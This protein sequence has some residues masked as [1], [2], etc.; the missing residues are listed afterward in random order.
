MAPLVL[1][2]GVTEPAAAEDRAALEVAT[3]VAD[4]TDDTREVVFRKPVVVGTTV[5]VLELLVNRDEV[6]TTVALW[7]TEV[8]LWAATV[9]EL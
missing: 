1:V 3:E 2:E 7:A 8:E 5:D 4:T 6:V 9:V